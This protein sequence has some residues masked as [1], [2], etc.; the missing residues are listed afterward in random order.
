MIP[1]NPQLPNILNYIRNMNSMDLAAI[2]SAVGKALP[3][4]KA[5]EAT[6]APVAQ[7]PA[8][9]QPAPVVAPAAPVQ[10]SVDTSGP[11]GA[12]NRVK[13]NIAESK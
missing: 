5:K 9:P 6:P 13:A 10:A 7:A 11:Y 12:M 8:A 4:A 1:T 2:Q 3:I